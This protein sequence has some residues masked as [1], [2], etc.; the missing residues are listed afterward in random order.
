MIVPVA[1]DMGNGSMSSTLPP[2]KLTRAGGMC[3]APLSRSRDA[4]KPN[5]QSIER[6][7]ADA[8]ARAGS[9]RF[10]GLSGSTPRHDR[11]FEYGS[12]GL[13]AAT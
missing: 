6:P 8:E 5:F 9:G 10:G 11:Y 3:T 2:T 4:T 12:I 7:A 1:S 13:P